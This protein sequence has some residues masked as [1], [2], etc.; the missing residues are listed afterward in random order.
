MALS[1]LI[2]AL[3]LLAPKTSTG[4]ASD[5]VVTLHLIFLATFT[6]AYSI[7]EGPA[8]FVISAEVFPL[9]NRE[10]GMSA[11]VFLNFLGAGALAVFTPVITKYIGQVRVLS[12]FSGTNL[13][14][15][16]ACYWLVP[17]T[18]NEELEEI[19]EHLDV[20]ADFAFSYTCAKLWRKARKSAGNNRFTEL[21][22]LEDEYRDLEDQPSGGPWLRKMARHF[23]NMA[24]RKDQDSMEMNEHS[25]SA[26]VDSCDQA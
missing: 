5:V 1:L 18:V 22:T 19:F 13:L 14:A 17:S 7:G 11:A 23:A 2:S 15:W 6:V 26:D 16:F 4:K 9:V 21:K 8:A 25:G 20:P 3:V 10:L 12:L 24:G